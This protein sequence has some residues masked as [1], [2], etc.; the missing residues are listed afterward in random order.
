MITLALLSFFLILMG[1]YLWAFRLYV[2][3]G[4]LLIALGLVGL[5][6]SLIRTFLPKGIWRLPSRRHGLTATDHARLWGT[7]GALLLSAWVGLSARARPVSSDFTDL[8]LFWLLAIGG[9]VVVFCLPWRRVKLFP[10]SLALSSLEWKMLAL[11]LGVAFFL[12]AFGLAWIPANFGGDEGTQALAALR[13]VEWPL[14]NPFATGWYSVPTMSFLAY[15]FSMRLFGATI[16]GARALSACAGTLTVL[17]TFLLGREL[18]GKGSGWLAALVLTFSAYHIHFSR[19]ASNQIFDPLIGA[20]AFWLLWRAMR[21]SSL[22]V[23][24]LSGLVAGFGW[25]AYFG[26]RWVT[27]LLALVIGWR[28]LME[29]RFISRYWRG[30]LVL[31]AGWSVV[32]LPLWMWY[33]AHPEDLSARYNA[34][35]IFASGWLVREVEI[36]GKSAVA[37]LLQQL[38]KSATAFHLTPDPTFWY[39]PEAPLLD[40][41]SGAFMLVGIVAAFLRWRWPSRGMI[42]LWFCSTVVMAWG[43]TENPPSSQRGTILLPA[44]ALLVAWG[45]EALWEGLAPY[46]AFMKRLL[47][48]LLIMACLL[49]CVFYFGIYT[50][51]RTYGNPT[52]ESATELSRFVL[53]HPLPGSTVYF[54]GPPYLYWEFG[55]L[56]FSLRDQHGLNVEPESALPQ[57]SVPARFVFVPERLAE[58][59]AITGRYPGGV[60]TEL[61][62]ADDRLLMLVY[63]WE[64]TAAP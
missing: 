6:V 38:W 58:L 61:R 55:A 37:L 9:F 15:G 1:T 23:W 41:V 46:K 13:L 56:A 42:L 35:S 18:S 49:N 28:A 60:T 48:V 32:T 59:A 8:L 52:A 17:A 4:G 14:E 33:L 19:L 2:W 5:S 34:V 57:V 39:R 45:V 31:L 26:A 63:D 43:V 16:A 51:R 50:P 64:G 30:L 36:T 47:L 12:R 29:P 54:F 25:Y 62:A 22:T 53:S 10:G 40:F 11:L 20:L 27:P 3:D 24:G 21:G 44:V 7:V